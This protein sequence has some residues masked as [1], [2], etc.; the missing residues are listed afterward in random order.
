MAVPADYPA[1][2][3]GGGVLGA[4]DDAAEDDPDAA[5]ASIASLLRG[6]L[7]E[8]KAQTVILAAIETNTG[9]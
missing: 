8:L 3:V 6:I 2:L 7:E 4:L 1:K 5:S 9:A